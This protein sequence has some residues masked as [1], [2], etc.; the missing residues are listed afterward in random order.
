MLYRPFGHIITNSWDFVWQQTK[1]YLVST[2]ICAC[3]ATLFY[4]DRNL[5]VIS[6]Y[7]SFVFNSYHL[8]NQNWKSTFTT[9][10]YI[11]YCFKVVINK[12]SEITYLIKG[13]KLITHTILFCMTRSSLMISCFVV[14]WLAGVTLGIIVVLVLIGC[15]VIFFVKR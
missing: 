3:E 1:V 14:G 2:P 11:W 4:Q 9:C 15:A 13:V 12:R 8:T 10:I 6:S 7:P 5:S